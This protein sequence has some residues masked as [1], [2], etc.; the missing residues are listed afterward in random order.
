MSKLV[1]VGVA[2]DDMVLRTAGS[3]PPS[4]PCSSGAWTPGPVVY[5]YANK[6]AVDGNK[7]VTKA[8][9]TFT[10]AG[11]P[12]PP[13]C[14]VADISTVTLNPG[15]TILKDNNTDLLVMGDTASDSYGNTLTV[16][17]GSNTKLK[18]G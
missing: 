5:T 13:G 12:P 8:E 14:K 2:D 18:T 15:T 6:I 3:T 7:V 11:S 9:C 1:S 4:P 17:P 16:V 10:W